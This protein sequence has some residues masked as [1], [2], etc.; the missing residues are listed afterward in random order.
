MAT[1]VSQQC[2]AVSAAIESASAAVELRRHRRTA[3]EAKNRRLDCPRPPQPHPRPATRLVCRGLVR[4]VL[5]R[6]LAVVAAT[7]WVRLPWPTR[8]LT[9]RVVRGGSWNNNPR[10]LRAANRNRNSPGNTNNNIGVLLASTGLCQSN[11]RPTGGLACPGPVQGR[12]AS[13]PGRCSHWRSIE[14]TRRAPATFSL[15]VLGTAGWHCSFSSPPATEQTTTAWS[16][17]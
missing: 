9:Q 13:V 5:C 10:N 17:P 3:G 6:R 12:W 2:D 14:P 7:G 8:P 16:G 4:S 11:R 1:P 15:A